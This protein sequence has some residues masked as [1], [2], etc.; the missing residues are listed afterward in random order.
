[1]SR[2]FRRRKRPS[3]DDRQHQ[4]GDADHDAEGEVD[5]RDRRALVTRKILEAFDR[6]VPGMGE[7]EAAELRN[8]DLVEIALLRLRR[9]SR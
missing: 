2:P 9:A 7:I 1:M 5:D 6:A 4:E 8:G 3:D